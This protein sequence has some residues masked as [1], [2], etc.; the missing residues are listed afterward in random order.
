[1][2][3]KTIWIT[4]EN[5][6]RN[7]EISQA[8]GIRLFELAEIDRIAN[9][10]WKYSFGLS[11][12]IGILFREKPDIV[13]CQNPSLILSLFLVL[14]KVLVDSK[15]IVDAHN[16][17]LFPREGRSCVLG[18]ISR[19]VQNRADLT[20]VTNTTLKK[21]VE[22]NGGRGFVLQDKIPSILETRRRGLK[23]KKNI[24]FIC[25]YADDEPY[26]IV[27]EAA[28]K[29]DPSV[30]IYVTGNYRKREIDPAKLPPNVVLTGYIPEHEYQEMLCSVDATI[31]L[32][33][34]DDCLVCGAYESVA[35]EKPMILSKTKALQEYFSMG[36]VY[37]EHTVSCMA[38]AISQVVEQNK[39]L[40]SEVRSLKFLRE[41]QWDVRRKDFETLLNS[42][43]R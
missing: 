29:I 6:R 32:T 21:H 13:I 1:M 4:W 8:L 27:F 31:D 10:I 36:A 14:I 23:G 42:L 2:P 7:R 17:G 11:K 3:K 40:A 34:R 16:A 38:T 30:C 33:K 41:S 20:I 12:T 19:F 24:L 35:V 9:V 26:E 43:L 39:K 22:E 25:S 5:Q 37:V 28:R 18:V 15:V